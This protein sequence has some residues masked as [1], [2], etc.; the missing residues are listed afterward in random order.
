[1]FALKNILV[2]TDFSECSDAALRYG[3]ALARQFGARLHVLHVV[4]TVLADSLGVYGYASVVPELQLELEE[5]DRKRLESLISA[6]D[7]QMLQATTT[8]CSFDTPAHAID[9]YARSE[10]VDLIVIGTHGR[11]GLSHLVLG[12]VAEKVV[13]TAPCPVLTVRVPE[14]EATK[15]DAGTASA[16]EPAPAQ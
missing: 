3:R 1:M 8:L 11:R 13:R 7:R 12:S 15:P 16:S 4:E 10:K 2:A 6:D 5:S 14:H 9:D